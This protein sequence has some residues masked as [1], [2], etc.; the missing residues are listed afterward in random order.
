MFEKNKHVKIGKEDY[1]ECSFP[2]FTDYCDNGVIFL[3]KHI[4]LMSECHKYKW[5]PDHA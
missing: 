4:C 2:D 3:G 1:Y 5:R